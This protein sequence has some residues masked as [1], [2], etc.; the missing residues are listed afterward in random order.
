M[1]NENNFYKIDEEKY[2]L[3]F[4]KKPLVNILFNYKRWNRLFRYIKNN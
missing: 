1:K 2:K 4:V 3:G